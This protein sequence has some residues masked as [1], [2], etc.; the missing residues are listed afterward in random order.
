M[1]KDRTSS[2]IVGIRDQRR[3]IHETQ[4]GYSQVSSQDYAELAELRELNHYLQKEEERLTR[5]WQLT[6]ESDID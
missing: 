1:K 6:D 2:R 5:Q 3:E 4:K